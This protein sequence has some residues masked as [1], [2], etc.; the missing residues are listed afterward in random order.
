MCV[1]RRIGAGPRVN[2]EVGMTDAS[3]AGTT[4]AGE[5]QNRGKPSWWKKFFGTSKPKW[6]DDVGPTLW[7]EAISADNY[8]D[9][10]DHYQATILEQYKLCVEMAD[11]VSAR[12]ALA[13]TFFLTLHGIVFTLV[14][15]FWKDKPNGSPW[16]LLFP[17]VLALGMCAAWFWL[18]RSYR[19]LNSGKFAVIATLER[20]LPAFAYSDGE[21]TALG[22]GEDKSVYWP[23]T[24]LEQ[25]I[26][27]LFAVLYIAGFLTVLFTS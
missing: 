14:G 21:W 22:K 4:V 24:H 15:V 2:E 19:Q 3:R 23:L 17:L 18:V 16:L 25:W 6:V 8:R 5:P 20:R 1:A 26:P 9:G 12:R 11:R 27:A 13:N 10:K 7:N